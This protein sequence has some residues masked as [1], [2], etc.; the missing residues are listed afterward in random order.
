ME[1]NLQ[2]I[3]QILSAADNTKLKHKEGRGEGERERTIILVP[4]TIQE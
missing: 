4:L 1:G 3:V 2:L